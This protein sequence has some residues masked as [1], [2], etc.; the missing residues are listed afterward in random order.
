MVFLYPRANRI[1]LLLFLLFLAAAAAGCRTAEEVPPGTLVIEGEGVKDRALLT[2]DDLK[3][4]AGGLVEA[5]YFAINTYGTREYFRFKGVWVWHIIE[6]T[7]D[8]KDTAGTVTFIGEDGYTV[9][10]SLEEVQ[11]EDYLDEERPGAKLKMILA[12][13]RD[14]EELAPEEGNPFQLVVGQR[15]PGDVNKPY[16]VRNVR[17]IRID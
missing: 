2:L 16:W 11:R 17:T 13:E 8:L 7:V 5:D 15:E 12:W 3:A 1:A 6:E 14:G 9:Q 4:M 10:Y